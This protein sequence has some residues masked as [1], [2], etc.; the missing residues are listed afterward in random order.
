[1]PDKRLST[2][3]IPDILDSRLL[4]PVKRLAV[5]RPDSRLSRV[6]LSKLKTAAQVK[7]AVPC[8]IIADGEVIARLEKP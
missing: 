5:D 8:L 4:A 2:G 3:A 6:P 1:M 7:A